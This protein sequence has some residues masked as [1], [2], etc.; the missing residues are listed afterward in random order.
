MDSRAVK[1]DSPLVRTMRLR[2][3]FVFAMLLV[4][5]AIAFVLSPFWSLDESAVVRIILLVTTVGLGILWAY[6][7]SEDVEFSFRLDPWGVASL[8]ALGLILLALNYNALGADLPWK[9]D[10]DHHITKTIALWSWMGAKAFLLVLPLAILFL[11][12]GWRN[13][14]W[15]LPSAGFF[16]VLLAIVVGRSQI[17][18]WNLLRYPF[19]S[20]WLALIP[21]YFSTAFTGV[22]YEAAFRVLPFL[23][24]LLL[25]WYSFK[26]IRSSGSAMAFL[27]AV[28]VVTLPLVAYYASIFYLEMPAVALMT[29]VCF[30]LSA[31]EDSRN[32]NIRKVGAWYALLLIGFLKETVLPFLIVFTFWHLAPRI[33]LE[34]SRRARL[35]GVRDG[36]RLGYGILLP[37]VV[38]LTYRSAF[39]DFRAFSPTFADLLDVE[40]YSILLGSYL[41]QFGAFLALMGLGWLVLAAEAKYRTLAFMVL[42]FIADAMLHIL[43]DGRF[44]G[45]SRFNLFLLPLII[46][47]SAVTIKALAGRRKPWVALS[48]AIVVA[49]NLIMSPINRDG[50]KRPHWG[51]YVAEVSEHYYPYREAISWL[52]RQHPGECATFVVGTYRYFAGFYL[53]RFTDDP[54]FEVITIGAD[55]DD[56]S[57]IERVLQEAELNDRRLVMYQV[58]GEEMEEMPASAGYRLEQIFRNDAHQLLLFS[59]LPRSN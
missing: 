8:V 6:L 25:G 5:Y 14:P 10:E 15:L 41:E 44:V 34:N 33:V 50:T 31:L 26:K 59:S 53:E 58:T 22:F 20:Y 56:R 2:R 32:Q 52:T 51:E 46:S 37:I 36:A 30:N 9:G 27:F 18:E 57:A 45:Y 12:E 39:G 21:L 19:F 43:D 28:S 35:A 7:S 13:S 42:A 1:A 55:E 49:F 23:S 48:L 38:Y 4:A 40:V 16:V 3:S 17:D 24:V 54:C 29:I 11:Y 47:G